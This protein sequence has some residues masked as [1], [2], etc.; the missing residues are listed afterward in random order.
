MNLSSFEVESSTVWTQKHE[1]GWEQS[2][3]ATVASREHC[4]VSWVHRVHTKGSRG[5]YES[6]TLGRQGEQGHGWARE[7]FE[8]Q[9]IWRENHKFEIRA[10]TP[11]RPPYLV[12]F[13][14]YANNNKSRRISQKIERRRDSLFCGLLH[15]LVATTIMS[16]DWIYVQ[17]AR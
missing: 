7:M 12:P 5:Q 14:S 10:L 2:P 15:S 13:T 4:K 8:M 3:R 17:T 1:I 11:P 9:V 6:G 16:S